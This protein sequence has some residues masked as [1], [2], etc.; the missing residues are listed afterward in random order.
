MTLCPLFESIETPDTIKGR[1]Q[2]E[3]Y[4]TG[5][6]AANSLLPR[7]AIEAAIVAIEDAASCIRSVVEREHYDGC[8]EQLRALIPQDHADLTAHD[9]ELHGIH[10][11]RRIDE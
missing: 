3:L 6:H 11:S 10:K 4:W 1:F 2:S 5:I 8:I 9:S 7:G